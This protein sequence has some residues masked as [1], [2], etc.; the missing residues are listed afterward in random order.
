MR[1][2]VAVDDVERPPVASRSS[3][4]SWRP[5]AG[6]GQD[7]RSDARRDRTPFFRHARCSLESASP[8]TYSIAEVQDVVLLAE[9]EDLRD[10]DVLDPRR[11][12][13]L[14]EE[15][16]AGTVRRGELREDRLDGDELL[17]P[18]LARCR[19]THTLAMPP[20]ARGRSS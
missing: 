5:G 1:R 12:A 19:A 16:R 4:A 10:V 8:S 11:D 7:R 20:S 14:V 2:D 17:E 15:H 6:V 3:W 18:V 13:R 9:V